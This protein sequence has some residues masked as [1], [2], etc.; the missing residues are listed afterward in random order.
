M[1]P[2]TGKPYAVFRPRR[3]LVVSVF[4]ALVVVVALTVAALRIQHGGITGWTNADTAMMIAFAVVV[5]LCVL[6]FGLVRAV[7]TPDG[8]KVH[9]LVRSQ[10]VPWADIV[11]VQFGGG[12]PWLMLDLADTEQL[13]VMAVQRAD[14]KFGEDEAM[15]LA[16]LVQQH[17]R[18][19]RDD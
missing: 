6:R 7:P 15:R 13:A 9:N 4:V 2:V 14:G 16:I 11:S 19:G 17:S 1:P 18:T 12:A 5:A 10:L 3:A 8:L